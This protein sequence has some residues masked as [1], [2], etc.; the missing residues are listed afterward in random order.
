MLPPQENR[1]LIANLKEGLFLMTEAYK[2]VLGT[3]EEQML[4]DLLLK[5]IN[6]VSN[7]EV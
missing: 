1:E 4:E 7:R 5:Y 2:R 3:K 6:M